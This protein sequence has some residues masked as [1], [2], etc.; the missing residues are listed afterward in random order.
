MTAAMFDQMCESD[1]AERRRHCP[2]TLRP[3]TLVYLW[4]PGEGPWAEGSRPVLGRVERTTTHSIVAIDLIDGARG[5]YDVGNELPGHR[6]QWE[7]AAVPDRRANVD[8][9][10]HIEGAYLPLAERT[11]LICGEPG[12][13]VRFGMRDGSSVSGVLTTLIQDDPTSLE[14]DWFQLTGPCDTRGQIVHWGRVQDIVS[15]TRSDD[16]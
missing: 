8:G 14:A 16:C 4:R 7:L 12:M 11:R 3:G 10:E 13:F 15:I 2:T 5:V 1:D 9:V 6:W